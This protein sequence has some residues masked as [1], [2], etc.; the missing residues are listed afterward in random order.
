MLTP[1]S[2]RKILRW[3]MYP[4]AIGL[5]GCSSLP[6]AGPTTDQIIDESKQQGRALFDL[7]NVDAR[8]VSVLQSQPPKNIRIPFQTED[9]PPSLKIR[10]GDTLSVSVWEAASG[11]LFGAGPAETPAVG[12]RIPTRFPDQVVAQD[13]A[14]TIPYA[15]RVPAAGHTPAEVEETIETRLAAEAIEP[16][17]IVTVAKSASNTATVSGEVVAG[18]R[19]PLSIGGDHLLDVIAAAGGAKSAPYE[20]LVRLTR[21][22]ATVTIPMETLVSDPA[23]NI[24]VWPGDDITLIK[25]P[26]TFSVFGAT[27]SNAE[28]P[29]DA[30][31]LTLASALAK[32]GGLLD[33]RADPKGV[34]LFRFEAPAV[35]RAL[36]APPRFTAPDGRAAIVY[37]VNLGGASG[38]FLADRFQVKRNDMIYV[39]NAK[40]DELLKFFTLISTITGPVISG[41]VVSRSVGSAAP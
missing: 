20:T 17:A 32:G 3:L 38:Y 29:I 11:G 9:K 34:F 13:G 8:V 7:V 41:V 15:G 33:L 14:I 36:N 4:V 37:H 18:A 40:S 22:G 35:A 1:R 26:Q 12:P 2:I 27:T 6:K 19:I 39:A 25:A 21:D 23:E 28:F 16:Q 5:V 31:K 10:V 30:D 24:Y